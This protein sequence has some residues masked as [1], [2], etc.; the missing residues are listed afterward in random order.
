MKAAH[1]HAEE[2][3]LYDGQELRGLIKPVA[4]GFEA[5][6]IGPDNEPEYLAKAA[7]RQ[8]AASLIHTAHAARTGAAAAEGRRD[9]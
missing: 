6:A 9:G 3:A 8:E 7:T 4:S 1:A 2:S 5:F